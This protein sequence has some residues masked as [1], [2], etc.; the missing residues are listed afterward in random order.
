[1]SNRVWAIIVSVLTFGVFI[2][3]CWMIYCYV[4]G[5]A[6][7]WNMIAA[8]ITMFAMVCNTI[9]AWMLNRM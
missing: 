7:L 1:M 2:A 6:T 9:S 5:T 8:I 4:I 3:M